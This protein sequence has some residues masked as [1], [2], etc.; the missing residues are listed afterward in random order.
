MKIKPKTSH[1]HD[2]WHGRISILGGVLF[3]IAIFFGMGAVTGKV[4]ALWEMQARGLR[5][6]IVHGVSTLIA[7]MAM[8]DMIQ[9][10]LSSRKQ[11]DW[12]YPARVLL[13]TFAGWV[14]ALGIASVFYFFELPMVGELLALIAWGILII[15][16]VA[17]SNK[18]PRT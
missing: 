7:V 12:R 3:G 9:Q 5:W 2:Q 16:L 11:L 8:S 6:E 13:Q 1:T 14:A 10:K 15:D 17:M 4:L 18:R